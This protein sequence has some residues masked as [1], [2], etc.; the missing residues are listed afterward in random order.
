MNPQR[1]F[2]IAVLL[3]VI[4]T[5]HYALADSAIKKHEY[6]NPFDLNPPV[7]SYTPLLNTDSTN[8]RILIASI[9]DIDG[10]PTTGSG[11]P[12]LYW[13]INSGSWNSTAGVYTDGNNYQFTFG[14]G[15]AIGDAVYYYIVAQDSASPP[16]VGAYPSGGAG[17]FTANPPAASVPPVNPDNYTVS[18][19]PLTGDFGI[20]TSLFN[21]I[22]GK[23]LT[24]KKVV[25]KVKENV[26]IQVPDRLNHGII[27]VQKKLMEVEKVSWIPM[28]NGKVYT[29]PLRILKSEHPE[30]N[31]P[32]NM[33]GIYATITAAVND[34]NFRGVSGATRLLLDDI[35]YTTGETYPIVINV[36][37]VSLPDS[38]NT[39]T[40]KPTQT[41]TN[42]QNTQ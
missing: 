4:M 36:I 9:T 37:N 18:Y 19:Y 23:Y 31:F 25:T 39:V 13:K 15:V 2:I 1:I 11:L 8:A 21:R 17:G 28:E 7:I 12:V 30:L 32:M 27:K 16:N 26:D 20:G 6:L 22:T 40:I 14:N 35:S 42:I 3:T 5:V 29:G 10:V 24:F 34:L 33:N 38:T 41:N